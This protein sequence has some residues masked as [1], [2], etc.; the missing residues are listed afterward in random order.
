MEKSF[1]INSFTQIN[2]ISNL[3]MIGVSLVV[4]II[5]YPSFKFIQ[6]VSFKEYH[7]NYMNK[8]SY[9]VAPIMLLEIISSFLLLFFNKSLTDFFGFILLSL[10]WFVTFFFIVPLH[11]QLNT[12]FGIIDLKKL[13][14]L[15]LIRTILWIFKFLII[16]KI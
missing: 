12:K 16:I 9:V 3:L 7:L 1:L 13:I 2:F 5:I 11:N 4:Q 8:M 14:K 6:K 10:V 15:N